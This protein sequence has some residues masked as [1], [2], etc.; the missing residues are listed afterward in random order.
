MISGNQNPWGFLLPGKMYL[1]VKK[2]IKSVI[3]FFKKKCLIC[4]SVS[5][6]L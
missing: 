3:F 5:G 1:Y 2:E 6:V 4:V